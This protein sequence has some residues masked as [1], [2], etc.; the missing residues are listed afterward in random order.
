MKITACFYLSSRQEVEPYKKDDNRQNYNSQTSHFQ[1]IA[2]EFL[3]G[4]HIIIND[5]HKNSQRDD[6]ENYTCRSVHKRFLRSRPMSFG[7]K[8]LL[9]KSGRAPK[10]AAALQSHCRAYKRALMALLSASYPGLSSK[11]NIFFLYAST[12]GWSNGLTPSI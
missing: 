9:E 1:K 2:S 6:K 10:S 5:C 11:A 8:R 7:Q 4:K 3:I 12:P